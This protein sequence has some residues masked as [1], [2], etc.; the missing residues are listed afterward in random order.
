MA[1]SRS[2]EQQ[3]IAKGWTYEEIHRITRQ[4]TVTTGIPS[5]PLQTLFVYMHRSWVPTYTRRLRYRCGSFYERTGIIHR[6]TLR[7]SDSIKQA[8][9]RQGSLGRSPTSVMFSTYLSVG[10]YSTIKHT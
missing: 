9:S 1:G 8:L 5:I 6:R 4:M 7:T 2:T 3:A 10:L